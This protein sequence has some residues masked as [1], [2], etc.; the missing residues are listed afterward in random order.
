MPNFL[1]WAVGNRDPS[2]TE[3]ITS[4]GVAINLTGK[5]VKAKAREVGSAILLVD[6]TAVIVS[7]PD[8]TVRYDWT[9]DDIAT[10]G[11]LA[12][13]RSALFWWEVTTTATGKTQN[14]MEALIRVV[15]NAPGTNA[16]LEVEEFKATAELTGTGF[17]DLDIQTMIL[18]ASRGIDKVTG[19]RFYPDSDANQ[20]RY[21]TPESTSFVAIDDLI[22]L[23]ALASDK[24]GDNTFG[25]TWTVNTDF[26]LEPLNAPADGWPYQNIRQQPRSSLTFG[27]GVPRSVR[28]TGKFGWTAPPEAVKTLTKLIAARLVKRTREAPLGFVELGLEGAVVRAAGYARDPDYAFLIGPYMRHSGVF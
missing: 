3:T 22:T 21:Y 23:T 14:M 2:I 18:A 28:V 4:D 8:G 17:A 11:I 26:V 15:P 9:A 25:D 27:A 7:A 1:E 5:T 13:P 12:D 24:Y 20:V 16:Y 19:R 10:D 6:E